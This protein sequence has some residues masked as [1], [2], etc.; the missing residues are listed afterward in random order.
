[1]SQCWYDS[2][3][4]R[5]LRP[6]PVSLGRP[7]QPGDGA[8]TTSARAELIQAPRLPAGTPSR[9]DIDAA[10]RPGTSLPAAR[11]G[12][13]GP[14]AG[15]SAA[16]A[17]PGGSHP[18]SLGAALPDSAVTVPF[19]P[20]AKAAG[21]EPV[22]EEQLRLA[23]R[24]PPPPARC[25][26]GSACEGQLR[27]DGAQ[28]EPPRVG[29][30][31]PNISVSASS[32]GGGGWPPHGGGLGSDAGSLS[33]PGPQGP[34][35]PGPGPEYLDPLGLRWLWAPDPPPPGAARTVR[36]EPGTAEHAAVAARLAGAVDAG[37]GLL[38]VLRVENPGQLDAFEARARAVVG[39]L[40]SESAGGRAA[41]WAFR[42]AATAGEAALAALDPVIGLRYAGWAAGAPGPGKAHIG[43]GMQGDGIYLDLMAADAI[44]RVAASAADSAAAAAAEAA[45]EA[46]AAM[47]LDEDRGSDAS[48]TRS[49]RLRMRAAGLRG[50]RVKDRAP[51]SA[52]SCPGCR[53]SICGPRAASVAKAGDGGE[54]AALLLSAVLV[55]RMGEGRARDAGPPVGKHCMVDDELS[56]TVFVVPV[57]RL[58]EIR[59]G[60]RGESGEWQ[61]RER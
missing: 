10:G 26:L 37:G 20:C 29:R 44:K 58:G 54:T 3:Q 57:R 5:A 15:D 25:G 23:T 39:A 41:V 48:T 4:R 51:Y 55:G 50:P 1:M 36:V 19:C 47:R 49:A 40:V 18:P 52:A 7:R 11:R 56:P 28:A 35:R 14:A 60:G 59:K 45:A 16:A 33:R 2:G 27:A 34:A 43:H 46:A 9:S 13:E 53:G 42:G 17:G 38:E 24:K 61:H 12:C 22:C 30:A 21:T 31:G 6:F 32:Q 8:L